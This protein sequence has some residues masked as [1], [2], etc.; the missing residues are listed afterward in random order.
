MADTSRLPPAATPF[1]HIRSCELCRQRKVKCDRQQPCSH[2]TRS[3]QECLYPSGPGRAPK[4]SRRAENAQLMDKL[5]RLEH[6]IKRLASEN[7]VDSEAVLAGGADRGADSLQRTQPSSRSGDDDKE[8]L[9]K[10]QSEISK[11]PGED[12]SSLDVQFGR[13]VVNDSMSYYVGNVLWANLANEVDGIR[14]MVQEA[15]EDESDDEGFDMQPT[16]APDHG[17]SGSNA[18]LFGFRAIAYSLLSYHPSLSQAVNLF[19]VFTENVSP[20]IRLFHLPSLSRTY[21]DSI[22]ALDSLS[23]EQCLA[24]LGVSRD[25]ATEKYRFSAEQALARANLLNTHSMVLL[26]AAVLFLSALRNQDDSRTTW[27]L[28]AL[29]FYVAQSMGLHRDGT[30]F[31]LKPFE[32]ELRRRLWWYICVLD[33]HSSKYQEHE[34]N[35]HKFFSDTKLPLHVNDSDLHPDMTDPPV[36]RDGWTDMTFCMVRCEAINT[37]SSTKLIGPGL[38]RGPWRGG[39]DIGSSGF[40][41]EGRKQIVQDFVERITNKYLRHCDP[42]EPVLLMSSMVMKL[43]FARFW[44]LVYRP[45]PGPTSNNARA[46]KSPTPEGTPSNSGSTPSSQEPRIPL[47]PETREK[48]FSMSIEVLE[49]STSILTH[50]NLIKWSWYTSTFVQWH[51]IGYVLAEICCRPPSAECDRAWS[52]VMAVYDS[53]IL[54]VNEPKGTIWKPIR[55]LLAKA[56]YVRERQGLQKPS[57]GR[58][59]T[60]SGISEGWNGSQNSRDA[61]SGSLLQAGSASPTPLSTASSAHVVDTSAGVHSGEPGSFPTTSGDSLL[62][63]LNLPEDIGMGDL[64]NFNMF[65]GDGGFSLDM[66]GAGSAMD[67]WDG[68]MW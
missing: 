53:G 25:T 46:E 18:A 4:R 58:V 38:Q 29:V 3:G 55:R 63:L 6:I 62:D 28:T 45:Q 34:A 37:A 64:S 23:N 5:S 35:L 50:P 7:P 41:V 36:E 52:A 15:E 67:G 9:H 24:L 49:L 22:A 19:A 54:R 65:E 12:A 1:P 59:V 43:I 61:G 20:M 10:P 8:S 31:G 47:E 13:L 44:L 17:Q 56:R 2:C 33:G 16:Q 60:G 42:S 14:D 66:M 32:T 40:S 30:V 68:R 27:S 57:G 39:G 51:A 48:L 21:W 26:Q 11:G